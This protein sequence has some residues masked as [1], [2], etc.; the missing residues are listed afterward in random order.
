MQFVPGRC[1][2]IGLTDT[3]EHRFGQ[4]TTE[5]LQSVGHTGWRDAAGKSESRRPCKIG[6]DDE[7]HLNQVSQWHERCEIPVLR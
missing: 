1:I 6:R 3:A 2:L 5:Q 7:L 4:A